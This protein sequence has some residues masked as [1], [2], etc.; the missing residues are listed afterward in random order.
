MHCDLS[1]RRTLLPQEHSLTCQK[2]LFFYGA[3][4]PR[5]YCRIQIVLPM[6]DRT[7]ETNVYWAG[8]YIM[9]LLFKSYCQDVMINFEIRITRVE[10]CKSWQLHIIWKPDG[11]RGLG[12]PIWRWAASV[13]R[14]DLK[15]M[16]C[17]DV[18]WINLSQDED[19]CWAAVN[20]KVN[21]HIS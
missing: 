6:A 2:T 3:V 8:W 16:C 13:K 19:Q 18:E 5:S 10:G 20:T 17:E 4:W 12:K 21:I 9:C 11:K 7:L 15:E 14:M 1:K